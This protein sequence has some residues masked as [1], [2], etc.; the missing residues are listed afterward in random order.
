MLKAVTSVGRFDD[1]TSEAM[2]ARFLMDRRDAIV[3]RYLPAVN[4]VLN[5]QLSTDGTLTFR[6]A[7]VEAAVAS[8]P[9]EYVVQWLRFDN[10]TGATTPSARQRRLVP[11]VPAPKDL[12]SAAGSY[13][14]AEISATGGPPSWATPAHAYFVREA[15]WLE[16]GRVRTRAGRQS[17]RTAGWN[18]LT[19]GACDQSASALKVWTLTP[20]VLQ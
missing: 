10:V 17:S 7:A 4:P 6:N 19:S 16:A 9:A 2:L 11:S 3:R 1:P 18:A 8:E 15:D 14:R 5:V 20:A 13:I 12:P